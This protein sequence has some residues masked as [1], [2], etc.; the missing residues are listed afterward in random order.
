MKRSL[1]FVLFASILFAL[2]PSK[3][4]NAAFSLEPGGEGG[5]SS[6]EIAPG[7]FTDI[8]S[9]SYFNDAFQGMKWEFDFNEILINPLISRDDG[10]SATGYYATYLPVVSY[11]GGAGHYYK[12]ILI[13]YN[14]QL[15]REINVI[16]TSYSSILRKEQDNL[17]DLMEKNVVLAI[18]DVLLGLDLDKVDA[19]YSLVKNGDITE[20]AKLFVKA[21]VSKKTNETFGDIDLLKQVYEIFI[22]NNNMSLYFV[23]GVLNTQLLEAEALNFLSKDFADIFTQTAIDMAFDFFVSTVSKHYPI[24]G[25]I[26]KS[27]KYIRQHIIYQN[28]IS[29]RQEIINDIKKISYMLE[30]NPRNWGMNLRLDFIVDT[31]NYLPRSIVN[32]PTA[33]KNY[34]EQNKIIT[35]LI[36]PSNTDGFYIRPYNHKTLQ[37]TIY[38]NQTNG[39]QTV[40]TKYFSPKGIVTQMNSFQIKSELRDAIY[41]NADDKPRIIAAANSAWRYFQ[42]SSNPERVNQTIDTNKYVTLNPIGNSPS[43]ISVTQR[44]VTGKTL[45]LTIKVSNPFNTYVKTTVYV[46]KG[47]YNPSNKC[48][49]GVVTKQSFTSP[50]VDILGL[51]PQTQY[52]YYVT[53]DYKNT[54]NNYETAYFVYTGSALTI[55]NHTDTPNYALNMNYALSNSIKVQPYAIKGSTTNFTIL[56]AHL[57]VYKDGVIKFNT[58]ISNL[59]A[60]LVENL[61]PSTPY[62]FEIILTYKDSNNNI[63]V[64][65]SYLATFTTTSSSGSGGSGGGG[66]NWLEQN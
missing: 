62:K 31:H 20:L 34:I 39:Y 64:E 55:S 10:Y 48:S 21:Y 58:D 6:D 38:N 4:V 24:Y 63:I 57:N 42:D 27:F 35:V 56:N 29:L 43:L 53:L 9:I 60:V 23:N 25:A 28:Q 3:S 59:G 11:A 12:S 7:T 47:A 61:N 22:S 37:E 1:I 13:K 2:A 66:T 44:Y 16:L 26:I 65:R 46:C 52:Q 5:S 54:V 41:T 14:P 49:E 18:S 51:S 19:V 15:Y 32:N 33:L 30:D 50:A 40:T 45:G 8:N 36:S 17:Q